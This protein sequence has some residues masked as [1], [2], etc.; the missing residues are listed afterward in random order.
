MG[1]EKLV[2]GIDF[3]VKVGTR[4]FWSITK[5][6]P[7]TLPTSMSLCVSRFTQFYLNKQHKRKLDWLFDLGECEIKP[8]YSDKAYQFVANVYQVTILDLFN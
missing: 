6:P 1:S 3:N 8:L 2:D 5:K 7:L 4:G